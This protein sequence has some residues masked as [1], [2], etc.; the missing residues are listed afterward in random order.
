MMYRAI[1]KVELNRACRMVGSLHHPKQN[2]EL[3]QAGIYVCMC[4]GVM[5]PVS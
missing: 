2:F 1:R 5:L 3:I 4:C